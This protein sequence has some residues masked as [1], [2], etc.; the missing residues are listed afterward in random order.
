VGVVVATHPGRHDLSTPARPV[1]ALL[2]DGQGRPLPSPVHLDLAECES[3]S[4]VR[5]LPPAE[6]RELLGGPYP[7]WA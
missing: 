5:S 2:T 4:I 7:E 1:V 3:R 6:R